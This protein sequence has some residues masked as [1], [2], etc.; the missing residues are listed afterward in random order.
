MINEIKIIDPEFTR[1]LK[2]NFLDRFLLN[3]INDERDLPFVHLILKIGLT[4]IPLAVILYLPIMPVIWWPLALIYI[5]YNLLALNGPYTLALHCTSHRACFKPK[6]KILNEIIPLVLGPFFGQSP[7]TYYS[8]HIGM[9][10]AE[11][12]LEDDLSSTMTYQRDSLKDFLKY[13]ATF[14]FG[15]IAQL[16]N[17]HHLRKRFKMRDKVL[18]GELFFVVLCITLMILNFKATIAVFVLPFILI[19][20]IMMIGNWTQHAFVDFDEPGNCY[21]NSITCVNTPYNNICFND[22]YHINHHLKPTMHYSAYPEHFK[23]TINDFGTNKALVFNDFHYLQIWIC[24]MNKNYK[25]LASHLL[26]INH[27]FANADDAISVMKSRTHKMP[28]RGINARNY[29][30]G[31]AGVS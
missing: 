27:E 21:K 1:P 26:N 11:N 29:K 9:H 19:R 10:H 12:N 24:L 20:L 31:L 23:Q 25:K 2:Y 5:G 16:V 17:Y 15:V 18:K 13:F 6:Y 30:A 14:F 28:V 3:L 22:G 4:L 8:H 7:G